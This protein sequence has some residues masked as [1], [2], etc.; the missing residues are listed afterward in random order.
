MTAAGLQRQV[1]SAGLVFAAAA[2]WLLCVE[3]TGGSWMVLLT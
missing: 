3:G 1:A 2:C